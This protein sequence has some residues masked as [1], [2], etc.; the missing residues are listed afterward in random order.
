MTAQDVAPRRFVADSR[1][2]V[3]AA[4]QPLKVEVCIAGVGVD[5]GTD[6]EAGAVAAARIA[7]DTV[8]GMDAVAGEAED[9]G[10]WEEDSVAEAA[11]CNEAAHQAEAGYK[12]RNPVQRSRPG[13]LTGDMDQEVRYCIQDGHIR[14]VSHSGDEGAA[15]HVAAAVQDEDTHAS[16]AA[17]QERKKLEEAAVVHRPFDGYADVDVAAHV[18]GN[19]A[20][21]A[22]EDAAA[23]AEDERV[24]SE[25][26]AGADSGDGLW[27]KPFDHCP[28]SC[29]DLL[30]LRALTGTGFQELTWVGRGGQKGLHD[31]SCFALS[32]S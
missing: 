6:L 8:G 31:Q 19:E 22:V 17:G 20:E 7:D 5:A 15:A 10:E 9:E 28:E 16:A 12:D 23:P 3:A 30:R 27:T 4:G 29:L 24:G 2:E 21:V 14:R 26:A 1:V 25:P 32:I 18:V 11:R 13:A